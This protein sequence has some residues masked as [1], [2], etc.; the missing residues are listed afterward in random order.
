MATRSLVAMPSKD[1]FDE[2]TQTKRC[3]TASPPAVKTHGFRKKL[4]EC[5]IMR[6]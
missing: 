1:D 6:K 3:A 5:V 4:L 2:D